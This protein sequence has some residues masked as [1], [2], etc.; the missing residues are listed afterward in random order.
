MRKQSCKWDQ[1]AIKVRQWSSGNK[2]SRNR[3]CMLALEFTS[4]CIKSRRGEKKGFPA[5]RIATH[6]AISPSKAGK[7]ISPSVDD[8]NKIEVGREN[9]PW[10]GNI[11][12]GFQIAVFGGELHCDCCLSCDLRDGSHRR[13][14]STSS[15][16]SW[17]KKFQVIAAWHSY[18][19]CGFSIVNPRKP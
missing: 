18:Q 3:Y 6:W 11:D 19:Y 8:D 7:N 5:M 2:K 14:K 15:F 16:A 10:G 9:R 4:K 13:L 12:L 1:N 17:Q